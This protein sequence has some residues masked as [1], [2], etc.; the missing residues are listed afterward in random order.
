MKKFVAVALLAAVAAPAL[1]A[2]ETYKLDPAHTYPSLEF[3]HMGISVWRG[4]FDRSSGTVVIDRAAK[5]GTVD[6]AID[7]NSI[8]FGLDAMHEKAV[9]EDFFNVA[10]YPTATYKGKLVFDGDT[11]KAVDGEVTFMGVTKPVK[12]TIN[13]FKCI[14]HPLT[15]KPMCGADA[16]GEMNWGEYGMKMSQYAQGDAGRVKLRIQVEGAKQE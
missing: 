1:A 3:S 2:P 6:V 14:A 15:K 4:K 5:T 16:E 13:L 8:D 12:L 9:S 10:K 7:P 11:P